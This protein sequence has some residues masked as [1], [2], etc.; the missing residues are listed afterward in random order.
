MFAQIDEAEYAGEAER[1]VG[2]NT[3]GNVK[4]KGNTGGGWRS[5]AIRRRQLCKKKKGQ[6]KWK[7]ERAH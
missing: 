2:E 6:N 4:G 3:E 7:N 5:E 1:G